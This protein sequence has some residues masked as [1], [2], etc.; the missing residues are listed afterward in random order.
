MQR[1][2]LE[3]KILD[4]IKT[5]YSAEYTGLL[6]V[7]QDDTIYDL[8]IGLPSY[9]APSII[10]GEYNTDD[11]FLNFIYEEFRK[12]NYMRLDIYKIVKTDE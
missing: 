7:H 1:I 8:K 6:E 11:E 12:R 5:L 2:D 9:M 4:Y 10:I 3:E